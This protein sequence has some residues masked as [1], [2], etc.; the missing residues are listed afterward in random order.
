MAVVIAVVV[1]AVA[2]YSEHDELSARH[3]EGCEEELEIYG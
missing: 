3:E 2:G 1:A